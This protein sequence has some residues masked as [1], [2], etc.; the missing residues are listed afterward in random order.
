MIH[1]CGGQYIESACVKAAAYAEDLDQSDLRLPGPKQIAGCSN[2]AT[3]PG[4][5]KSG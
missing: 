3:G 2:P 1:I 5:Y 4:L